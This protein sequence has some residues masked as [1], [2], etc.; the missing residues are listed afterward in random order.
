MSIGYV[1][2]I[3]SMK[4]T[5]F[6]TFRN[7]FRE[8]ASTGYVVDITS[9]KSYHF[10]LSHAYYIHKLD[11]FSNKFTKQWER[12]FLLSHLKHSVLRKAEVLKLTD[13]GQ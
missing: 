5:L 6:P 13:Y 10:I 2:P 1:V 9:M 3:T 4:S 12:P 11:L 8:Q 7:H